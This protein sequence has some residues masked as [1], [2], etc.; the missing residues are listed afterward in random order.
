[1]VDTKKAR[2]RP[3][4]T[5]AG[6]ICLQKWRKYEQGYFNGAADG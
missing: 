2:S 5:T 4:K 1:M 6:F 3:L